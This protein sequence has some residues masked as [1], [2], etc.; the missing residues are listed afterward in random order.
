MTVGIDYIRTKNPAVSV[1]NGSFR[2]EAEPAPTVRVPDVVFRC[3][4]FIGEAVED[5]SSGISGDLYATGFFIAAP[6]I[7]PLLAQHRMAYFVTAGHVAKELSDKPI[8][9]LVNKRG[10]GVIS[11]GNVWASQ[12][13]VHP[14]DRTADVAVIPVGPQPNADVKGVSVRDFVTNEDFTE[15]RVAIGDELFMTGLFTPIPGTTRNMPIVRHG[16]IA[17]LPEE[18]VQTKLGYADVYLIEARSIGGLSGSPVFVRTVD[19]EQGP[20][21]DGSIRGMKLLGLMHGHWDIRESEINSPAIEHDRKRGVNLGIGM[22][23]PATKIL[24]IINSPDSREALMAVEEKM[25]EKKKRSVP[26]MD[27]AKSKDESGEHRLTKGE[28]EQVLKKVS[29]KQR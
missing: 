13:W 9:F 8:C 1:C 5:D 10:G 25:V 22:V 3:V 6:F 27:S 16:N 29:R 7:S 15:K 12:W 18:Q 28:F 17:M 4:G 24:E 2:I 23:V 19:P 26:G 20:T 21:T 11:F 14:T